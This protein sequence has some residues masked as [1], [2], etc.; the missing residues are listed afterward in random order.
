MKEK[1]GFIKRSSENAGRE[2]YLKL[3]VVA[4]AAMMLS[5][6]PSMIVNKGIFLYYGD[7]NSQQMMFYQHANEVVRDVGIG[8]DWGTDLGSNF[9]GSY[10]FYLL[11]S[12]FFWLTTLFPLKAVA[13]L[14]PWMLAL[15]TAV[16]AVCAYAFIRRFVENKSAAFIGAMLYAFSGFQTYNVFFNHFHDATAFFPLLLLSFELLTQENKKG[17]FAI[18]VAVCATISYF[19]FVCE[20]VF[21]IIYFFIRMSDKSFRMNFRIFGMLAFEAVL[22]FVMS[23]FILLPSVMDVIENPRI[24]SYLWGLDMV[25]YSDHLR[26]PRI[27]QAFF[28]LSD[29]PARINILNSDKARWASLAGYLPMFSMCGVI[30]FMRT[31]KKTWQGKMIIVCMIMACVPFFNSAFILFNSSYYARWF[32]MPILIMCLMTAQVIDRDKNE[33]RFGFVPTAIISSI[34]VGIGLLPKQKDG[35]TVY[36]QVPKY[37]E[38]YYVQAIVT[39]AMTVMLFFAVYKVAVDR[40]RRHFTLCVMTSAACAV[41]MMSSVI[42]GA[43]QGNDN[44]DYI[45]RAIN[46]REHTDLSGYDGDMS[47]LENTFYR[48]DTSESVDNWCMYWGLSSMRTFHSVVPTSIMDFYT[49]IG[50]TRDVASRMEPKLYALRGLFSVKYYFKEYSDKEKRGEKEPH[51]DSVITEMPDFEYVGDQNKFYVYKNKNFVPMGFAYDTYV[52]D[53]DLKNLGEAEKPVLLMHSLVLSEE[54]AIKYTPMMTKYDVKS[55]P[56]SRNMYKQS[57]EEKRAQSC[58][59][60]EYDS[61]GFEAKIKLDSQKLVFFSVPYE[62][63]WSAEVNGKP[64]DVEKVSYGFMAVPVPAGDSTITFKF[65]AQGLTLGRAASAGAAAVLVIYWVVDCQRRKKR[66]EDVKIPVISRFMKKKGAGE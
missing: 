7:F 62:K 51:A 12:P 28:M 26:I 64:V 27:F 35:Q 4:F 11:G 25:A 5:F 48:I 57:C 60:F 53:E 42:Y 6:I 23:F 45:E 17:A 24:T 36:G 3:F 18:M 2:L 8:W 9:I 43:V 29:M 39:I 13:Y 58:Y 41:C 38:L 14:M 22:G 50:Q 20:V 47:G 63:G 44:A 10:S 40:R 59:S 66:G 49:S 55:A 33:L 61:Q 52:S 19:F 46:G 15:K 31:R 30:A 54:Q 16:A 21:T 32:Y 1:P 65:K 34:F 56:V 37:P